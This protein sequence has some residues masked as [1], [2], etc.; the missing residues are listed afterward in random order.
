[1]AYDKKAPI[2]DGTFVSPLL[3]IFG[4]ADG[5][6]E[7]YSPSHPPH[8]YPGMGTSG[9]MATRALISN[10][11]LYNQNLKDLLRTT[12]QSILDYHRQEDRDPTKGDDVG[13]AS[14]AACQVTGQEVNIIIA[15]DCFV[16]SKTCEGLFFFANFDEAAFKVE[17]DDNKAYARH[18]QRANG[19]KGRAWDLYLPEYRAKRLRTSNRNV[20]QGGF[21]TLNG[22]PALC[23]CWTEKSI[24]LLSAPEFI[25][26]GT[27]GM[28]PSYSTDPKNRDFLMATLA[29]LYLSG[30]LPD[31]LKWR[32]ETEKSLAHITGWPE[33]SAVELWFDK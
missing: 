7:G 27:D 11:F 31:V 21:A 24:S 10:I 3:G 1:M 5:V 25:I 12:N 14:F 23:N 33:A 28:L 2:E 15:G 32:D 6:T 26:L 13:G 18:L 19:N 8:P 17:D 16:F 30:G 9:Q 4:A 20:G 22:D 29:T